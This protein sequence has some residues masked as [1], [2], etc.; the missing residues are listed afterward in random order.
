VYWRTSPA[1]R[2]LESF[3]HRRAAIPPSRERDG[4]LAVVLRTKARALV[5]K[6]LYISAKSD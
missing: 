1:S 3:R 4:P 2:R 5:S 6:S